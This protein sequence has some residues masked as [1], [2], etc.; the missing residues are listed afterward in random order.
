MKYQ[1]NQNRI[2]ITFEKEDKSEDQEIMR[3]GAFFLK[4]LVYKISK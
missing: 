4:L 3:Y 2:V 1:E